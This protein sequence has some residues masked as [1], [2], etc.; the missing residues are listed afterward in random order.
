MMNESSS[1][2]HSING[3]CQQTVDSLLTGLERKATEQQKKNISVGFSP[4][5][6]SYWDYY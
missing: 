4:L 2:T 5:M 6:G 1:F 3:R